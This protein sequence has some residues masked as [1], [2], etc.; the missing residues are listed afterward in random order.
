[1]HQ[2]RR[3]WAQTCPE[4]DHPLEQAFIRQ[5][6]KNDKENYQEH[7]SYTC[8]TSIFSLFFT[9]FYARYEKDHEPKSNRREKAAKGYVPRMHQDRRRLAQT[10]PK[11]DHPLELAFIRQSNKNDKENCQD[12]LSSLVGPHSSRLFL[13]FTRTTQRTTCPSQTTEKKQP[14]GPTWP[15][16]K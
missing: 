14:S 3:R 10:C 5:S 7:F 1:M 13:C 2:D 12:H 9:A 15:Q 11:F 6:S 16:N 4:F 8:R